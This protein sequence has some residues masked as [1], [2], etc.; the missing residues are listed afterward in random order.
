MNQE[1]LKHHNI[2]PVGLGH[3]RILAGYAPKFPRT[4]AATLPF[5]AAVSKPLLMLLINP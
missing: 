1:K 4:L 3:I 5:G 2:S